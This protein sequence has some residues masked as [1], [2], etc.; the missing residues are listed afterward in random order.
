MEIDWHWSLASVMAELDNPGA[1]G[2]RFGNLDLD[3]GGFLIATGSRRAVTQA[4][5]TAELG[6]SAV[7]LDLDLG[8]TR[9]T[10]PQRIGEIRQRVV[11]IRSRL[12]FEPPDI[13]R[14]RQEIAYQVPDVVIV[15]GAMSSPLNDLRWAAV[16]ADH[17]DTPTIVAIATDDA[18]GAEA[19]EALGLRR[20]DTAH[21]TEQEVADSEQVQLFAARP[22][23]AFR[24]THPIMQQ[25]AVQSLDAS[26]AA[27]PRPGSP[28]WTGQITLAAEPGSIIARGWTDTLADRTEPTPAQPRHV[29][30]VVYAAADRVPVSAGG[31]LSIDTDY[32]LGIGIGQRRADSLLGGEA[33]FPDELLPRRARR[34]GIFVQLTDH[35]GEDTQHG[36]LYLPDQGPAFTCPSSD[37]LPDEVDW[38][39][40]NH[41]ECSEEHR[42]L[43]EFAIPQRS[44]R[45]R[46]D[47]EVLIYV[48]AAAVHKQV[49][50]LAVLAGEGAGA[51]ETYRLLH[52]F[53]KLP[54]LTD[55]AASIVEGADHLTINAVHGTGTFSFRFTAA[56]WSP[57]AVAVRR[58]L[59]DMYFVEKKSRYQARYPNVDVPP[60]P[61]R[62]MLRRLATVGRELYN[63]IFNTAASAGLAPMLQHEAQVRGRPPVVQI[64]RTAQRPFV[65]PWQVLYDLP[66]EH[67]EDPLRTC[68]SV[69]EYGPGGSA[70]W[71][72]PAT[73]PHTDFHEQ[74]TADPAEPAI[75]RPRGFWGLAH[76]IEVPEP[77]KGRSLDQVVT[78]D[79]TS[80][81][82]LPGTGS[83]LDKTR[84]EEHLVELRK[85]VTGF[86]TGPDAVVTA[87]RELRSAL[88]PAT[89]DIVYL[90][91]HAEQAGEAGLDSKLVFPDR[92][93]TSGDIAVWTRDKWPADHWYSRHPLV[94]LNACHTA[95]IVQSTMAGFVPNFVDGGA[96][97]VIGTETLID[98]LTASKAMEQFLAAF[99]T[100]STVGE[101][102]R[103]MRWHL[104]RRGNLLGFTYTPYCAAS[105]RLRPAT[106]QPGE[107][108]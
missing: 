65:V 75:L 28:K 80:V 81:A 90:L 94:V 62:M 68:P 70:S 42:E 31:L 55:R 30:T 64:A 6:H 47:L 17:F 60:D 18:T 104:L 2:Q 26:N 97:G 99:S 74:A 52:T 34:I 25:F 24:R 58:A 19:L 84:L 50:E 8:A 102:I 11:R 4:F 61:Y 63:R 103:L 107:H 91:S 85:R 59:T 41:E 96:A 15:S 82:V 78:E 54:V 14:V 10:R 76:L 89:M 7:N 9:I 38:D 108:R 95:E 67:P 45:G 39:V 27:S 100:G 73:C 3:R 71:P 49:V 93:L 21:G 88:T 13:A 48:G 16:I 106:S 79:P 69:Q 37:Q 72:P 33:S 43:A 5:G 105:L 77:P 36:Y 22:I 20:R 98:Q 40:I 66:I 87:A 23:P 56:N 101:A 32:L 44:S 35:P 46:I 1:F 92:P 29:N 83:R 53:D 51:R 12:L 57:S 86:P